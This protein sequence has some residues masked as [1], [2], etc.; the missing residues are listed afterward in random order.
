MSAQPAVPT[1]QPRPSGDSGSG[2]E[3][4]AVV[5]YRR[6]WLSLLLFP[7]SFVGAFVVGEGLVGLFGFPSGGDETPPLWVVLAASGPALLVFVVPGL[8]AVYFG[9]RAM[10]LGRQAALAPAVVGATIAVGFVGLNVLAFV[11]QRVFA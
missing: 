8:L 4:R 7:V 11:V 3:R 6:A 5:A 1:N 10:S 9:R 2:D